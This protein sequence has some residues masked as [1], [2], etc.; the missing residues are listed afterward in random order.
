VKSTEKKQT[1]KKSTKKTT[2]K[3]PYV[4]KTFGALG[5]KHIQR[6]RAIC[7]ALPGASEKLSHGEATFFAVKVFAMISNNHHDDGHLAVMVPAAD[8][9]QEEL[10]R[11]EPAKYYRPPYVGSAGWVGIELPV[12][13]DDELG[14]H[15]AEAHRLIAKKKLR[16]TL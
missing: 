5:A 16:P 7:M 8:G 2:L 4:R 14:F 9:V 1:K 15:I 13:S 6:V 11:T 3:K 12:V 10:A